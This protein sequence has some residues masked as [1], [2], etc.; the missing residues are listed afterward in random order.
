MTEY[1]PGSLK[2]FQFIAEAQYGVIPTGA[3]AWGGSTT[4]YEPVVQRNPDYHYLPGSAFHG[5][6]T[7]GPYDVSCILGWKDRAGSEWHDFIALYG[8]GSATAQADTVGD[9]TLQA[10]VYDAVNSKHEWHFH[11]GCKITRADIIFPQPGKAVEFEVEIWSQWLQKVSHASVK[12]IA[13]KMQ[14]VTPGADGSAETGA[15][16]KWAATS[17]INLAA[18]GLANWLPTNMR[19]SLS[20]TMM[21]EYGFKTGD[22]AVKYPVA[23]ALHEGEANILLT[24][25]V[26]SQNQ[27]YANS[28]VAGDAVTALTI[29]LDDETITLSN[30][31]WDEPALPAYA[32]AINTERITVR[33]KSLS[34]A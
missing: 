32:Q 10:D 22:D 27:T 7:E 24:A 26:V 12:T 14:D 34:I 3:M 30:G 5:E 2:A 29:P 8:F 9:F 31:T 13:G 6:V 4:K 15:I 20:R 1:P 23:L 17:Q 21:R 19:L 18:G 11:N 28:K 33:F 25:E 16:L